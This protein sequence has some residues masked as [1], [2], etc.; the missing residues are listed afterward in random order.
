MP[1]KR[2]TVNYMVTYVKQLVHQVITKDRIDTHQPGGSSPLVSNIKIFFLIG[3]GDLTIQ[4][5]LSSDK[6]KVQVST[7]LLE[8]QGW[9]RK[10]YS[11]LSNMKHKKLI[12]SKLC[13]CYQLTNL[14][15]ETIFSSNKSQWSERRPTGCIFLGRIPLN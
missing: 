4:P 6:Q 7:R 11:R 15:R 2:E 8:S 5:I 13:F 3:A 9:V 1:R 14:N 10:F 12:Q